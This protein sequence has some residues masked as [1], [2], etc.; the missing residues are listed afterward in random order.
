MITNTQRR[1]D[2]VGTGGAGPFSYQFMILNDTD[3]AVYVDGN[4]KTLTTHYTVSG[5]GNESGGT[6][7]FT[8]G[9]YPALSADIIV[10]G[11]EPET[12]THDFQVAATLPA[13][14][15]E[16]SVDKLTRLVQQLTERVNR[17]PVLSLPNH[18]NKSA[19]S[20]GALTAGMYARANPTEDGLEFATPVTVPEGLSVGGNYDQLTVDGSGVIAWAQQ[21]YNYAANWV[22]ISRYGNDLSAAVTAIGAVTT[23]RLV[24]STNVLVPGSVSVTPNITLQFVAAGRLSVTSSATLTLDSPGQ[25]IATATQHVLDG[26][27]GTITFTKAGVVSPYWFGALGDG[28][29]N[30]GPALLKMVAACPAK[31]TFDFYVGTFKSNS[32][33]AIAADDITVKLTGCTLDIATIAGTGTADVHASVSVLC[34][35]KVTGDRFT[36]WDGHIT[37]AASSGG[38]NVVGVLSSGVSYTRIYN[39][40]AD[41]LYCGFWVGGG[42]TDYTLTNVEADSCTRNILLGF[43]PLDQSSPQVTRATLLNVNSHDATGGDGVKLYGFA[44][45]VEILGGYYWGNSNNGIDLYICGEYVMVDGAWSAGNGVDGIDLKYAL[46]SGEGTDQLGFARRTTIRASIFKDNG[47]YGIRCHIE[48]AFTGTDLGVQN[49]TIEGNLCEGNGVHGGIFGMSQGNISGNLFVRNTQR[50][51]FFTS[52]QNVSVIGNHFWDNGTSGANGSGC[53]WGTGL[54]TGAGNSKKCTVIGNTAGDT[55]TAGSRTQSRGY[56][57]EVMDDCVILGNSGTNHS[58]ADFLCNVV[59]TGGT[60]SAYNS[61]I[62]ESGSTM[63][64]VYGIP[65]VARASL[66]AA[67]AAQDGL[68]IMDDNGTDDV[69]LMLYARGER[70]RIDGGADV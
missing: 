20:L 19:L 34:G 35:F 18:Y 2:I 54:Y 9:N 39:T 32:E 14:S 41:T 16:E 13:A 38:K 44:R 70:F 5:V 31:S 17:A 27:N 68:I 33:L 47:E 63:F 62:L 23:V 8:T 52:C 10:L 66:P 69:N 28:S 6:I 24:I 43:Q 50:G 22:N 7:T 55:R 42:S 46:D 37:G 67:G 48:A 60:R 64:G 49:A 11:A 56:E 57:F 3:L 25:L 45:Q 36:L 53:V 58:T 40:K 26:T 65:I 51:A 59:A 12:Q 1:H 15:L 61:G 4:L 29:T 30:D 21:V